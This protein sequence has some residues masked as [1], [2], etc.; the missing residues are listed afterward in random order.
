[1]ALHVVPVDAVSGRKQT[2]ENI[3]MDAPVA[4]AQQW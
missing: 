4:D 1:V 3:S 2:L